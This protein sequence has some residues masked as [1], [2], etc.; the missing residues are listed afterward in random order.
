MCYHHVNFKHVN[1]KAGA[2]D[3]GIVPDG[4]A[5]VKIKGVVILK[6]PFYHGGRL[7]TWVAFSM[8]KREFFRLLKT[9]K[10]QKREHEQ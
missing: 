4:R 8:L 7:S 3:G 5:L 1:F 10:E 9:E 2:R 6:V